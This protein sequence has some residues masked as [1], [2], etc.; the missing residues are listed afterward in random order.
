MKKLKIYVDTSVIGGCFDDEFKEFSNLL[1]NQFQT[2]KFIPVISDV[3]IRELKRAP[4]E[5]TEITKIDSDILIQVPIDDEIRALAKLYINEGVMTIKN[6]EDATHI[7]AA[8]V[9]QVDLLVSWNFKHIVNINKIHSI[10]AVNIKYGYHALEIYT[11][12]EV[13]INE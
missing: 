2:G 6:I 13:T 4:T 8:V 1:F 12:R 9:S 7:A 5:V 10:N 11:P 3:T